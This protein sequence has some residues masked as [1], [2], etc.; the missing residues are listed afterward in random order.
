MTGALKRWE[1]RPKAWSET[2]QCLHFTTGRPRSPR[3]CA[4]RRRDRAARRR[5]G[6]TARCTATR[7]AA[8][9]RRRARRA[10]L[11]PRPA[12]VPA[13]PGLR[14]AGDDVRHAQLALRRADAGAR[15]RRP[16]R[17][18]RHARRRRGSP[19]TTSARRSPRAK[20]QLVARLDPDDE[21]AA[22][23]EAAI[24]GRKPDLDALDAAAGGD[25]RATR[26]D[27]TLLRRLAGPRAPVRR[28]DPRRLPGPAGR[29]ARARRRERRPTPPARPS[30]ATLLRQAL[31]VRDGEDCPVCGTPDVLDDAWVKAAA[32]QAAQLEEQ[33]TALTQA[34]AQAHGRAPP[35]RSRCSTATR[36][37]P[38]RPREHLGL[39]EE[40]ELERGDEA[41]DR[42]RR[43]GLLRALTQKAA[44]ELERKRRR[45]AGARRPRAPLARRRPRRS[46]RK[47]RHAEGAQGRREVGQGR[48]RRA[49]RASASPR[50]PSA[51]SPTGA[52]CGRAR[53]WTCTRSRSRRSASGGRADFDVRADG[54]R[55]P[56][57]SA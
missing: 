27:L 42:R 29:R 51:R 22:L 13:V 1:K 4:G 50:S 45:V 41:A 8:P 20:D 2:W 55:A 39:A 25:A 52:S 48:R 3:S 24:G 12:V 43:V 6:R 54:D 9:R 7:A 11:G 5:S 56:T 18:R 57:R 37:P 23:V 36:S 49:A 15:A 28:A 35:R 16:G 38:R 33:A 31:A 19:T 32:E 26:E 21:R 40:F 17:A 46:R 30:L 44:A 34:D 10:R 14:R 47:R 53:A